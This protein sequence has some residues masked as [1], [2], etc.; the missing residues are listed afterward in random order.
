MSVVCPLAIKIGLSGFLII[1]FDFMSSERR[2]RFFAFS[3]GDIIP[4]KISK[5]QGL[6]KFFRVQIQKEARVWH[7]AQAEISF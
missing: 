5:T 1:D 4:L 2:D 6:E 3:D 7:W